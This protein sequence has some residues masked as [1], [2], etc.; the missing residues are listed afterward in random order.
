MSG[1]LVFHVLNN[2]IL[3]SLVFDFRKKLEECR[4]FWYFLYFEEVVR[5]WRPLVFN[6]L[7]ESRGSRCFMFW[8]SWKNLKAFSIL[9]W[10][11]LKKCAEFWS[12]IF[13]KIQQ[14]FEASGVLHFAEVEK[15]LGLL[16]FYF[17]EKF[18]RV[19]TPLVFYLWKKVTES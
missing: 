10:K 14:N 7:K 13:W 19:S 4:G 12:F 1:V 9:F 17:F 2:L 8:R 6:F 16:V 18:V 3:G 15:I 5:I 11:N